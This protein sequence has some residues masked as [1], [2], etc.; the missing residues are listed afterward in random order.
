MIKSHKKNSINITI[1]TL[2]KS[3]SMIVMSLILMIGNN[4]IPSLDQKLKTPM[5]VE[6][7]AILKPFQNTLKTSSPFKL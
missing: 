1:L 3:H 4:N 5:S 2:K 7:I 6:V